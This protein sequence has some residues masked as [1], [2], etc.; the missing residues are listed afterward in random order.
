M[1]LRY[2]Y[3][4]T[5]SLLLGSLAVPGAVSVFLGLWTLIVDPVFPHSAESNIAYAVSSLLGGIPK[6]L[7]MFFVSFTA[8]IVASM[9][10][11]P[12]GARF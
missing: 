1:E 10:M 3:S 4:V 8:M 5:I 7:Q 11:S 9:S 12:H 6:G 2:G